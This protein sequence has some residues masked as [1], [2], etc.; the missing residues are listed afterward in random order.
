MEIAFNHNFYVR[1]MDENFNYDFIENQNHD[2]LTNC[3]Y[4]K[5]IKDLFMI[6]KGNEIENLEFNL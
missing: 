2:K 5:T 3:Y 4:P 1:N 6:E